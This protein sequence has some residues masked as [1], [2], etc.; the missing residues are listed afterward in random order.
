MSVIQTYL[1]YALAIL[2]AISIGINVIYHFDR[3]ALKATNSS[4]ITK[5]SVL[6]EQVKTDQSTIKEQNDQINA[7]ADKT[8]DNNQKIIDLGKQLTQQSV[9]DKALIDK[10]KSQPAPKSCSSAADYLKNNLEL[11]QW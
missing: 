2:L 6:S 5:N 7:A 8:K 11:Y 4:L 3:V 9:V 1:A 10:L